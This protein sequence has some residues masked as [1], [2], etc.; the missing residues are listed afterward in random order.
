MQFLKSS[1]LSI[2]TILIAYVSLA[3]DSSPDATVPDLNSYGIPELDK[4]AH[5][6]AY[7][8][9]CVFAVM[10]FGT[11]K[12]KLISAALLFYG[13]VL[14]ILQTWVPLREPSLADF[15]ADAVGVLLGAF[16]VLWLSGLPKN[17]LTTMILPCT[18]KKGVEK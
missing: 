5:A 15:T 14:E 18:E 12:L 6:G 13:L 2:Y 3:N 1:L 10:V 16:F 7:A 4:M 11:R 9:F 8:L 17:R